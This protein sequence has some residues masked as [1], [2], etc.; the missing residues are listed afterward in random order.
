MLRCRKRCEAAKKQEYIQ[1]VLKSQI[2][3][4]AHLFTVFNLDCQLS[5]SK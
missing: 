2:V 3:S 5:I 4:I 1:I